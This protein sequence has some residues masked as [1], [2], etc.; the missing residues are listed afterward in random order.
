MNKNETFSNDDFI[1]QNHVVFGDSVSKLGP[2]DSDIFV[3]LFGQSPDP[4]AKVRSNN[5]SQT[6]SSQE[7]EPMNVE[8]RKK[9]PNFS[10]VLGKLELFP[11]NLLSHS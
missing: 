11:P 6:E 3:A 2:V 10:K 7:L 1:T 4:D 9:Q 8:L 5:M